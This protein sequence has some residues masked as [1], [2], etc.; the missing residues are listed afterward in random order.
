MTQELRSRS[1]IE[2]QLEDLKDQSRPVTPED[3]RTGPYNLNVDG[4]RY[5]GK[6]AALEWLVEEPR[7]EVDVYLRFREIRD[8]ATTGDKRGAMTSIRLNGQVEMLRW[9]L[10]TDHPEDPR[11]VYEHVD[12]VNQELFQLLERVRPDG[13]LADEDLPESGDDV[14]MEQLHEELREAYRAISDARLHM[15]NGPGVNQEDTDD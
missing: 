9:A 7:S 1:A 2:A 15:I 12:A 11:T 14:D 6:L 3:D 8:S 5:D 13:E 4:L 10:Q